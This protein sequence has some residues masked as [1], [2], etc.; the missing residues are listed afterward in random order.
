M[1]TSPSPTTR[2]TP[3]SP[4]PSRPPGCARCSQGDVTVRQHTDVPTV[5][6][7]CNRRDIEH[8]SILDVAADRRQHDRA[9]VVLID[10]A[11]TTPC[12]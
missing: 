8:A 4:P 2:I 7:R 3:P 5:D 1:T 10:C 6:Q 9:F 11:A 12:C